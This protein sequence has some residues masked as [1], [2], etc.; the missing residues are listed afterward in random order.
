M[1]TANT[2]LLLVIDGSRAARRA[3]AYVGRMI[4]RRPGFRLCLAPVLPPLPPRLLEFRGAENPREEKRLDSELKHKQERWMAKPKQKA[5]RE[6]AGATTTLKEASVPHTAITTA[7]LQPL[8]GERVS[9]RILEMA[10]AQHCD[11][12]V[13]GR[14]PV[15]WFRELIGGD[16]AETLVQQGHGFTIWVVE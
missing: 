8:D 14:E 16:L 12:I 11:T 5:E 10:R 4:G 1:E 9:D 15:S 6:L 3:V 2:S 13:I 7:F